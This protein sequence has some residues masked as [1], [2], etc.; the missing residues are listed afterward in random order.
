M[1]N[2]KVNILEFGTTM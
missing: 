1:K 2:K